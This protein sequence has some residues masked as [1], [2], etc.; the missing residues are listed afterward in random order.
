MTAALARTL[1][2]HWLLA[3]LV[4]GGLV[5]RIIVQVA[6]QPAILYIDS[7]RYL[8]DLGV[9]FPGGLNPIGY[10]LLLLGP[11]LLVANLT[12]VVVVQHLLGIGLG[13]AIYALLQRCGAR[14]WL[15]ALATA[16]VL[17][18][19]YQVQIE[20]MV[21]SDVLF[22]VILLGVI[23]LLIWHGPPGPKVAAIA[24]GL[25]AVSVLVRIVGLTLVVPAA[26]FV[27]FAAG[28][29]P[30]EGWKRRILTS[31]ALVLGFVGVLFCYAMYHMIWTGYPALGGSTGSVVFGRAA[32]VAECGK[33]DLTEPEKLVCPDESVSERKEIG[34]DHYIHHH[35]GPELVE[36]AFP[37]ID[38]YQ[39]QGSFASKVLR[40]Q[41]LDIIN[42]VLEDFFKGFAPTRTQS[43][44]D[45]PLERWQFQTEYPWFAASWYVVEWTELYDDGTISINKPLAEFLRGYQ[46]GGGYTPGIVLGGL[47][48][49]AIAGML[50]VGRARRSGLQMALLLSAGL[51]TTVLL[52][53]AAMEFSWRYQLP[54]LVLIPLAGVL[55][56]TA[57]FGGRPP[58]H[59]QPAVR[60]PVDVQ[61]T[62][63]EKE[64]PT[65]YPDQVDRAALDGYDERYGD[66]RFAPVV[67]LIA[68]YNEEDA[69]GAVL[70]GIPKS[71]CGLQV[72]TLVVVDG[73]TDATADVALRYGAQICI[74]PENRG[75]GAA[76]RLG[77]QLAAER[78]ARYI[79]TTDA[80]GQYDIKELPKLLS[81]LINDEAE[82]VTGSR[83]LGRS[84]TTDLL[85]RAGT[86]VFAWLVSALTA[87]QITDTTFGF[88]GM[89]AEVPNAVTL[90]QQQY[91]SSELLIGVLARGYRVLEQPMTMLPRAAGISK[92]GNNLLY[93]YRYAKVVVGTW[94]RERRSEFVAT[95]RLE[96]QV[97]EPAP[98]VGER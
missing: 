12:A 57:I 89:K 50:G 54:G 35:D 88:R 49:I 47:L 63:K 73:A 82:F 79:V 55:G 28:L 34:I 29:R 13:I 90:E 45:V 26:V 8:N 70:D 94:L 86:Y 56:I 39:V 32:V 42:G 75:Q 53:A 58:D 83:R 15:S 14:R 52:T 10:E 3:L 51:A 87:Q 46:L 61:H 78:G 97:T 37:E 19:A 23:G 69:L 64:M 65:T 4:V 31:G 5:L 17:L 71:S 95:Q 30:P 9:F 81:P 80:D 68:A 91:Q 62:E 84:E 48:L 36:E 59:N 93:G 7:F 74:A 33:L 44:G 2:R 98:A 67:V 38:Y 60:K 1:R 18:D 25:L 21:M 24:G 41:P 92:K 43:A 76:L 22:Q 85:R 40:N 66:H 27:L 16:P 11:V 6:Y 77:Y 20:Q 72:D 96:D